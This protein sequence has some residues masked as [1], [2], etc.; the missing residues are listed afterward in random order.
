MQLTTGSRWR[1][2]TLVGSA[3]AALLVACSAST[4]ATAPAATT[5]P[6]ATS[7]PGATP[8][9]QAVQTQASPPQA[10]PPQAGPTPDPAAAVLAQAAATYPRPPGSL[11][12]K[13]REFQT[14]YQPKQVAF[15]PD[16]E[17][18]W[19]T[20]LGSAAGVEVFE[21]ATGT[22]TQQVKLGR[23]G[24][25]EVIF[26]R[27]GGTAY[28]S[29]MESGSVF[30]IDTASYSVTRQYK[31][32]GT[33]TKVMAL[34]PDE[35]TL[36]ASNWTSNDVSAITLATGEVRRYPTV[37]TPRG[38]FVAP[39]GRSL[40][41]AG[42][43]DGDVVRLDLA[44]G[45]STTLIRTGGAMRHLVG[46]LSRG[47]L[48]A[49]DMGRNQ[50][51]VV[52]L[53]AGDVQ[54]LAETDSH[55]N[56]SDL[57]PDGRVLY[58]ANRGRNGASYLQKGPEWGSVVVIDAL[59][60]EHLDAIVGGNQTTALDVSPDGKLLAFSDFLDSRVSIYAVPDYAVLSA[61]AGGRFGAHRAELQK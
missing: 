47:R 23:Y 15:S 60:G 45:R 26:T 17:E 22:R 51:Y 57:T 9:G 5:P 6:P 3:F 54:P 18:L 1:R 24:A 33:W 52:D 59:T 4:D 58:V 25:V 46:D 34:S 31:T 42:Y 19:V 13:L 2:R 7:A 48:Y 35:Q 44:S 50:A 28:V 43:E 10:S 36:Y 41:V 16:G 37:R 53:Q 30:A 40:Y 20:P 55:P 49:N 27:D 38:L 11:H 39:D 8:A 29:Q 12:Q 14:G 32:G 61:G 21:V 56:T